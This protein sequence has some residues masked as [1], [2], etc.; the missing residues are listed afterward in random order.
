[1]LGFCVW[2]AC[3]FTFCASALVLTA[4][5]EKGKTIRARNAAAVI[6]RIIGTMSL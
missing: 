5:I 3:V 1:M 2:A 6:D 4:W